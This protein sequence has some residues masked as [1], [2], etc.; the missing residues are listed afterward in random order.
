M[1]GREREL[2]VRD[3]AVVGTGRRQQVG[4]LPSRAMLRGPKMVAPNPLR[5]GS[6]ILASASWL[7]VVA[8]FG[9]G[10]VAPGDG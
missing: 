3:G 9:L 8:P 2:E 1:G 7:M 6:G 4:V 10:P 5:T